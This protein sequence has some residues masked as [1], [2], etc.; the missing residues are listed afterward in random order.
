MS[1]TRSDREI[2]ELVARYRTL[3]EQRW[4][5]GQPTLEE[6]E[7]LVEGIRG[8]V[9]RDLTRR[10]LDQ[11]PPTKQPRQNQALCSCGRLAGYHSMAERVLIT[12]HGEFPLVRPYYY[13]SPCKAGFAPLDAQLGLDRGSTT[14]QIRRWIARLCA[15]DAFAEATA[16]L[17]E[18]TG[19][20][21]SVS[22]V[23]RIAVH[24]GSSLAL[25][26]RQ[27]AHLHQIGAL[28]LP[29]IRP[30]RLYISMDGKFVP[31]RNPWRRDGSQGSLVCRFGECKTGVVYEA[32]PGP[33][34]DRGVAR[35]AY[36]ATMGD[37]T[38]FGPL[39]ATLA[40]THGHH[41]AREVV[42]LNDGAP[43]I[44][45]V[46]AAYFPNAV[47]ILDYRHATEH[48]WKV[49]NARFGEESRE[50]TEW[51]AAREAELNADQVPA[52]LDA[53]AAWEPKSAEKRQLRDTEYRFFAQNAERMRY[54]TFQ[55]KG[56]HI[57][58]GVI[59]SACGHV[60]GQRL[61]EAGMHWRE[62]NA[63]AI[64]CLRAALRSTNP[65][66]LRPH[67]RMAA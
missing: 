49:A 59:E 24:I 17:E 57:A 66:D 36:V 26:L 29:A 47:E 48:L 42:V 55:E 9:S 61:D 25:A 14:V 60:V 3:L 33:A 63:D 41:L 12:R 58:S 20:A 30:D 11:Q 46:C 38:E 32:K 40:H 37:V 18:F 44:R 23:E 31:L 34:G 62:A 43:W 8:E 65:P 7:A 5:H 6:I 21:L 39:I 2:E 10:I 53:L 22:Q 50:G 28:P 13:C 1:P 16:D 19:V 45:L 64:V 35:R 4:P 27:Q 67:C 51:V 56:Y 52:V 15:K 54:K